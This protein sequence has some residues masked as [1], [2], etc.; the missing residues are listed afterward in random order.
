MLNKTQMTPAQLALGE[1]VVNTIGMLLAPKAGADLRVELGEQARNFGTKASER[2]AERGRE[3]AS[4]A[5]EAVN[6]GAEEVRGYVGRSTGSTDTPG[7][8]DDRS[9]SGGSDSGRS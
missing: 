6:R 1:P 9:T 5:R 2:L 4:H 3:M 7:S 8:F